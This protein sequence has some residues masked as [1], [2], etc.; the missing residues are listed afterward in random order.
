MSVGAMAFAF[1]PHVLVALFTSDS[2]VIRAAVPLLM[3]A[4]LFQLFDGAQ[5]VASGA[6]RGIAD[7]NFAFVANVV[8]HWLIGLPVALVLAFRF[9]MGVVGLWLG[10]TT[11]LVVV[12]L[13]CTTRFI[14]RAKGVVARA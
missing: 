6:L 9:E 13:S 4:A 2:A 12:A 1:V 10:L 14:L 8:A 5:G 7:V 3:I 11:G